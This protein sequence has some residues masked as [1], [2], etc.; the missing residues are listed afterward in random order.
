MFV[1]I[2]LLLWMGGCVDGLVGNEANLSP[3]SVRARVLAVLGNIYLNDAC[4]S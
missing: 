4:M 1:D 2:L 3:S